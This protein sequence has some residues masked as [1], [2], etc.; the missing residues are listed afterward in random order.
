MVAVADEV[1]VADAV[2]RDRR[3]APP[4]PQGEVDA[5]PALA[6]AVRRRP[7]AAV[8]VARAIDAAD[9]GRKRDRL[10]AERALAGAPERVHHLVE[11]QDHVDVVGLAAQPPGERREH[12]AAAS[13]LEVGLGVELIQARVP[14]HG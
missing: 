14:R 3:H 13:P 9:D 5:L 12:L 6:Q 11:R 4:A 10:E 8:E 2:D 1:Q 7:E